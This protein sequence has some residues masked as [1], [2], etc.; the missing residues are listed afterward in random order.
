M[1]HIPNLDGKFLP[2]GSNITLMIYQAGRDPDYFKS[3]NEF[4]PERFDADSIHAEKVNPFAYVPFSAGPRNCIGQKFAILEM[5][6]TVS[7]MLR[8][9]E[10]LPLGDEVQPEASLILHSSNGFQLG[11]KLRDV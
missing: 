9:F 11:L 1:S 3:P 4:I 8:H 10:L 6:S 2:A 7:K 5:K